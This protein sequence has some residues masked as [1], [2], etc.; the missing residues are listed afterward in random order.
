MI[1]YASVCGSSATLDGMRSHVVLDSDNGS[2]YVVSAGNGQK[3]PA[4]REEM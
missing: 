1:E 2:V 4:T 3:I